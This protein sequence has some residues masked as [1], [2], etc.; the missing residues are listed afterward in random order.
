[1]AK[2]KIQP[3]ANRAELLFK[4]SN[5]ASKEIGPKALSFTKPEDVSKILSAFDEAYKKIIDK[6]ETTERVVF[7]LHADKSVGTEAVV[8]YE[9]VNSASV[10]EVV[11]H[12]GTR[13][14][15]TIRVALIDKKDMPRTNLIHGFY[16]PYGDSGE[17]GF[18][19]MTYGEARLPF[20]RDLH[21]DEPAALRAF[22]RKCEAYWRGDKTHKGHVFLAT[23]EELEEILNEM[24]ANKIPVN[25]QQARLKRFRMRGLS[26][27][28]KAYKSEPAADSID[29][30]K[31]KLKKSAT[32]ATTKAKAPKTT[33]G[34]KE[35]KGKIKD[36]GEKKREVKAKTK[37][38]EKKKIKKI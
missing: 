37:S 35:G 34:E 30:G 3:A 1:M 29:L 10:F 21:G 15:A 36:K 17:G 27:L 8:P 11:K 31:I 19:G 33:A 32:A 24:K 25:G 38:V 5:C 14:K 7:C 2:L 6:E 12:S 9:V 18:Y 16:G 22:S 26:P 20:P 13:F 4:H 28:K 23:P